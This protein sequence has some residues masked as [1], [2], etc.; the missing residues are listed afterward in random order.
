MAT[1]FLGTAALTKLVEKI[2]AVSTA[3]PIKVKSAYKRQ[4][5]SDKFT[6]IYYSYECDKRL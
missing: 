6:G 5:L 3:I 4:R 2:K 1:K